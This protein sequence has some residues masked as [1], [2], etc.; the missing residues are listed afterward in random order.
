MVKNKRVVGKLASSTGTTKRCESR[1]IRTPVL[2]SFP[3]SNTALLSS[4]FRT[5]LQFPICHSFSTHTSVP[6]T[7]F[8][9]Y[10]LAP[11]CHSL[12]S[13]PITNRLSFCRAARCYVSTEQKVW[14]ISVLSLI[15]EICETCANISIA[16]VEN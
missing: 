1:R 2:A 3:N 9:S 13:Q 16:Q 6:I 11:L 12:A 15:C 4:H 8:C 5:A 7:L 10:T 14:N